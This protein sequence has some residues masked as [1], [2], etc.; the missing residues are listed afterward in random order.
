MAYKIQYTSGSPSD[1]GSASAMSLRYQQSIASN[2]VNN[3]GIIQTN[4]ME[5]YDE[6]IKRNHASEILRNENL[7]FWIT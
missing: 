1:H 5:N 3:G 4:E 6:W 7:D 2:S